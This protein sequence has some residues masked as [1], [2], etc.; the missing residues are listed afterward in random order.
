MKY[1]FSKSK[2]STNMFPERKKTKKDSKKND[3]KHG[4]L[5]FCIIKSQPDLVAIAS[6]NYLRTYTFSI[7][8]IFDFL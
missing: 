2:T 1:T 7:I 6:T 5:I 3:D 4:G 8:I